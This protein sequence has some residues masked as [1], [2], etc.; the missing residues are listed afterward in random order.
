[1]TNIIKY[2]SCHKKELNKLYAKYCGADTRHA[3]PGS[4]G[5][6]I[7]NIVNGSSARIKLLSIEGKIKGYIIYKHHNQSD[8]GRIVDI[9]G[10][11]IEKG[12]DVKSNYTALVESVK[13]YSVFKN[14]DYARIRLNLET[15]QLDIAKKLGIEPLKTMYEMKTS[16]EN[17]RYVSKADNITFR[18]FRK[19]IDESI[20]A[21]LQNTIFKDTEGHI[22]LSVEDII[23]EEQQDYFVDDGGIFISIDGS[24]VGYSQIILEK[25]ENI[26]PYIVNF[27]IS[28]EYRHRGLAS[29]LLNYTL[30]IIKSKGFSEAYIT[31]DSENTRAYKL[32]KSSGFQKINTLCSYLY[33]YK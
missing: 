9:D 1:M 10:I 6:E 21:Q 13:R 25:G 7:D 17:R 23:Y 29:M 22:D 4:Y 30:S 2:D 15:R 24:L 27:G 26:K 28:K 31:V 20:R 18:N 32:Y 11:Y 33:K 12:Y 16:L 14:Y 5:F 8:C 19:G 3:D